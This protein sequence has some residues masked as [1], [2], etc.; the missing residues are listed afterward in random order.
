[1]PAKDIFVPP[2]GE[3]TVKRSI[4]CILLVLLTLG[5]CL[6]GCEKEPQMGPFVPPAFDANAVQGTPTVDEALGWN[7]LDVNGVYQ[8]SVCGVV[9]PVDGKAD[10]YLTNPAKNNVWLKVRLTDAQGKTVYAETGLI[11]PGEYLKTVSFDTIPKNGEKISMKIMTYEPDTYYSGGAV[12]LNTVA[13]V[14]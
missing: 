3:M 8:V 6:V 12:A 5:A 9:K 14:N 10:I 4:L 13:K 11:K 1:M 2:K 7:E